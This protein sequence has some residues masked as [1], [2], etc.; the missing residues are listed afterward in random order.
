MTRPYVRKLGIR[1]YLLVVLGIMSV[2]PT[3]LLSMLSTSRGSDAELARVDRAARAGARS[4]AR[5]LDQ[6]IASQVASIELLA[7]EV[8]AVGLESPVLPALLKRHRQHAPQLSFAYI[9]DKG[10]TSLFADP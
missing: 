5:E 10:G 4:V 2:L 3:L 6:F 9:A 1:V 7:G 8:E